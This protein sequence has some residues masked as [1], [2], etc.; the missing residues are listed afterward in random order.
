MAKEQLTDFWFFARGQNWRLA[1]QEM[2]FC[3]KGTKLIHLG[4]SQIDDL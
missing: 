3:R 1:E 2:G 4:G